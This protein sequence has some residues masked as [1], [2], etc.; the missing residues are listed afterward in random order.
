MKKLQLKKEVIESLN[1]SDLKRV[2]GGDGSELGDFLIIS[3]LGSC[4]TKCQTCD[5]QKPGEPKTN[6]DM[7][8]CRDYPSGDPYTGLTHFTDNIVS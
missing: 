5:P 1:N 3:L 6:G 4:I 8:S 7:I 2:R